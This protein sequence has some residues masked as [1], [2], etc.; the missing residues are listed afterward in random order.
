[1][2]EYLMIIYIYNSKGEA[3][4]SKET[5]IKRR[6]AIKEYMKSGIILITGNGEVGTDYLDN[7]YHFV[8]DSSFRYYFGIDR[9]DMFG[10]IDIDNDNEYIFGY[11]FTIS[12]IIWMG[13]QP[14]LKDEGSN[15]GIENVGS[16]NDLKEF[17]K[18]NSNREIH[19]QPQYRG[20][21][22]ITLCDLLGKTPTEIENGSSEKLCYAI[23]NQRIYKTPEEIIEI[24][25]A[26]NI[27]REMHLKAMQ[28]AKIGMREY[29]VVANIQEVVNNHNCTNSFPT[30]CT[31]N[32]QTLHNHYHGNTLESGRMLLI[33]CGVKTIEGYCGDMTTTFPVEAKFSPKQ[34]S[35]Y[36][37]LIDAYN[38]AESI[39]KAGITYKE[40][41]LAT[42]TKI[43]EGLKSLGLIK[44]N[45]EDVVK[46]GAHALFMPH[47]LGHMLGMDVHD[48]ESF[49][50]VI[51]GY[52]GEQKST[53]FGLSS[54]R[55]GRVL[56]DGFVF[57]VE[58]GIYFIPDLIKKW[59]D[60]GINSEFLNFEKIE[61]YIDLGGMR[62]EGDYVIENGN[63]RR[64]GMKMP[65]TIEE[66]EAERAKAYKN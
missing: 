34:A 15:V 33:D 37:I 25:K 61:E 12:D 38:H 32:G 28:T 1:M 8:Q 4:F 10:V 13:K 59:K 56:E 29:E 26:V 54:L 44:G 11:D 64:L 5:Y 48:M 20:D 31:T 3:M 52:N 23:A 65:K 66:V 58:P 62:Y 43:A 47:G 16:Y 27:T 22:I 14:K 21:N 18:A 41:H 2:L 46:N 9:T 30:I 63:P 42:V 24:E 55:M 53:Q 40:V 7:T 6:R 36:N 57:T 60:E 35:I 19:Y 39:L 51:V 50:E 45:I 49:G 17:L